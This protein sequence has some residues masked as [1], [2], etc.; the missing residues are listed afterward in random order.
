MN[1]FE[2]LL[3]TAMA[4]AVLHV[5]EGGS[6]RLWLLAGGLAGVGMLNKHSAVFWIGAL[7][8]GLL[9]TRHRRLL[10]SRWFA[11]GAALAALVALPHLLW[12]VANGFPIL[13]LLRNGQ[14][15]K[16]APLPR[17]A[18][19]PARH[20]AEPAGRAPPAHGRPVRLGGEGGGG[21]ARLARAAARRAGAGA[22][23]R[24]ELR[25]GGRGG[26]PRRAPRAAGAAS[27][28]N[29]YWIWSRR[30]PFPDVWIVLGGRARDHARSFDEVV[31]VE[32]LAH[33]P[34]VMP[35][36]DQLEVFV[37]RRPRADLAALFQGCRQL[38]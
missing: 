16:N 4:F 38:I 26:R 23:L 18:P 2:P 6:P 11:A 20:R 8:A 5:V 14:L 3:W 1:A 30:G 36:E 7:V 33:D 31:P 12:Q 24:P 32:R 22:G 15:R 9:V 34:W 19:R 21:G 25:R 35:Y 29:N 17:A 28:H 10:W 27:C 37:V 13:E